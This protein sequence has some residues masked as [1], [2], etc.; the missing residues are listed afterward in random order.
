LTSTLEPLRLTTFRRIWIASLLCNGAQQIQVVVA[1]WIVLQ[2]TGAPEQVALVQTAMML[3]MMLLALPGGAL[4]DIYDRRKAAIAALLLA[5]FG[6][7]TQSILALTGTITAPLVLVC[8]LLIGTGFALFSPAWQSAVIELVG[9]K[10]LPAAV[11]LN[12]MSNSVARSVG[13]TIGGIA[14]ATVGASVAFG[15][16]VLLYVPMIAALVLWRRPYEAPTLPPEDLG[17]AA[18]S[19]L[20]YAALSPPVRRVLFR[21]MVSALG[22]SSVYALLPLIAQNTL[23]GDAGTYGLLLGAFGI[24][25]VTAAVATAPM[26]EHFTPETSVRI[27]SCVQGAAMLVLA[28]SPSATLS[29]LALFVTGACWVAN[30]ATYNISIQ[31]AVPGWVAGRMLAIF[32]ASVA[33]GLGLGSSMWGYVASGADTQG[34]LLIAG[35][36]LLVSPCFGIFLRLPPH[37]ESQARSVPATT[38]PEVRLDITG[39]SGA[40]ILQFGYRIPE[41][42]VPEF[43]GFMQQ[44]RRS[45][46]RNGA[47]AVSLARDIADPLLWIE[48]LRYRTWHDYVRARDRPT[49]AERQLQSQVM[50][51]HEGPEPALVRCLVEQPYES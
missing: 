29:A 39:R 5:F 51:L 24:G 13:P 10:S 37:A 1:A 44:I 7:L 36:L 32:H 48:T 11:A 25:A 14:A 45:H 26:R 47:Y 18:F 4:A 34:A 15:L 20:R 43:Y 22:T 6:A 30:N 16:N 19:G 23:A 35:T 46:E 12:S 42:R 2:L 17:R 9:A 50:S 38:S 31:M 41:D 28:L 40:I 33:V 27:Y 8:C 3:P 21:A 49:E